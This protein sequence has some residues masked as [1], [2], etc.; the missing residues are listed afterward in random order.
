VPAGDRPGAPQST[1]KPRGVR[2][3]VSC[4]LP[5]TAGGASSDEH[6]P[7]V[8]GK[9][10]ACGCDLRVGSLP[11]KQEMRVRVPSSALAVRYRY[12]SRAGGQP[13]TPAFWGRHVRL[14][15]QVRT[16]GRL[17]VMRGL[18][19]RKRRPGACGRTVLHA[20]SSE[21][22]QLTLN[23]RAGISKFPRRTCPDDQDN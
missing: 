7:R 15:Y 13:E 5:A 22:E 2:R 1:R 23:Q 10:S 14:G 11:S 8:N 6:L 16:A 3:G 9:K 4:Q 19:S 12:H 17:S 20:V 21:A 18:A